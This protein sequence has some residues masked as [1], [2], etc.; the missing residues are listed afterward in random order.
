MQQPDGT[1]QRLLWP[2]FREECQW[3]LSAPDAPVSAPRHAMK[4]M[5]DWRSWTE[6]ASLR[7]QRH[8]PAWRLVPQ[9]S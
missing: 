9:Y 7:A 2:D 8:F 6:A 5:T 4:L 3:Y 1:D